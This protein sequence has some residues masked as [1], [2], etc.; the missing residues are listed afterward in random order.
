M[1]K[2]IIIV[3]FLLSICTMLSCFGFSSEKVKIQIYNSLFKD[4]IMIEIPKPDLT[5]TYRTQ[6]K[7]KELEEFKSQ[8]KKIYNIKMYS[9]DA[10]I[11]GGFKEGFRGLLIFKKHIQEKN[12]IVL[13]S[14]KQGAMIVRECD[15]FPMKK[16]KLPNINVYEFLVPTKLVEILRLHENSLPK[17]GMFITSWQLDYEE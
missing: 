2:K 7:E 16:A 6:I 15:I 12:I 11:F 3:F 4:A 8:I 17:Q 13:Y 10:A 9:H 1:V 5:E 14:V